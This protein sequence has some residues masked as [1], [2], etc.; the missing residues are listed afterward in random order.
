MKGE[1][2]IVQVLRNPESLRIFV[3]QTQFWPFGIAAEIKQ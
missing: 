2:V 1:H 3:S